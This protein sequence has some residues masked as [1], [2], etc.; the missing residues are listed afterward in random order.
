MR[1]VLLWVDVDGP[2]RQ[3]RETFGCRVGTITNAHKRRM[4]EPVE[5]RTSKPDGSQVT[6]PD[7]HCVGGHTG[8]SRWWL[9][10]RD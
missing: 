10:H 5:R 2:G 4:L 7:C 6:G 9:G 3:S 1:S 8:W